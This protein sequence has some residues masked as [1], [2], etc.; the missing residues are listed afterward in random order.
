MVG[1]PDS[2]PR[3]PHLL[4]DGGQ[5]RAR[6]RSTSARSRSTLAGVAAEVRIVRLPGLAPK[7]DV[8][9]W[10]RAGGDAATLLDLCRAAPV[11][12]PGAAENTAP[13]RQAKRRDANDTRPVVTILAGQIKDAVDAIESALI[14]RGGLFQRANQIVHLG[15][16]PVI[17][18]DKREVSA[19]RIF[20][21]GEHALAEDIAEAACLMKW[22]GRAEDYVVTNPPRGWCGRCSSARV[23]SASR[24]CRGHQRPDAPAGRVAAGDAGL[25]QGDRPL[26]R[27][28]RRR[29]SRRSRRAR[30]RPT[31]T[32]RSPTSA[33]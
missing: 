7:G 2:L 15:E 33:T 20:E 3:R 28:S 16:A 13:A 30:R 32:G 5:R 29:L 8:E 27:P 24:S 10:I 25:R 31:R 12:A 21:R 18:A 11:Y 17:T 19:M 9:D 22:D 4:R 23:L 26:L 1:R 6:R 14:A